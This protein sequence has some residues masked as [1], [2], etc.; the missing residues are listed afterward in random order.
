MEPEVLA[1][2]ILWEKTASWRDKRYALLQ[3]VRLSLIAAIVLYFLY[4][5]LEQYSPKGGTTLYRYQWG[6]GVFLLVGAWADPPR[7]VGTDER[8]GRRAAQKERA[9]GG[10][11]PSPFPWATREFAVRQTVGWWSGSG[12]RRPIRVCLANARSKFPRHPGRP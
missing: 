2:H 6:V 5:M 1:W 8:P 4:Y 12:L 11:R 10:R 7:I 3:L 9:G